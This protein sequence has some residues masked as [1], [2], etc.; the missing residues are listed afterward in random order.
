MLVKTYSTRLEAKHLLK[1]GEAENRV[2]LS[3]RARQT[4]ST[5][6]PRARP[7]D[8]FCRDYFLAFTI[9]SCCFCARRVAVL[10]KHKRG[11][12]QEPHR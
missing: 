3:I 12:R 9:S 5:P 11:A 6:T 1:A 8:A 2:I 4:A 10:G 7:L